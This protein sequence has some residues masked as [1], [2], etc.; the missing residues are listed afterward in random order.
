MKHMN[1]T[2]IRLAALAAA[3]LMMLLL[4]AACATLP[5][6][7]E[8][9][10][11]S[12]TA[13][14]E[15]TGTTP[16]PGTQATEETSAEAPTAPAC[17][18]TADAPGIELVW[19]HEASCFTAASSCCSCSACGYTWTQTIG[20]PNPH[21]YADG[22][23]TVCGLN[24]G[25]DTFFT[26]RAAPAG[27]PGVAYL[28]GFSADC[29][30][31][32]KS[33][34]SYV[35]PRVAFF[36]GK[37]YTIEGVESIFTGNKYVKS[38]TIP[39]G[40]TGVG[41]N[42]FKGAVNL[43]EVILPSTITYIGNS[44][45]SGCKK[46]TSLTL[47]ENVT[48]I[49]NS[50][51]ENCGGL[52]EIILPDGCSKIGERAFFNC[53]LEHITL[54][55]SL[56]TIPASMLN[57]NAHLTEITLPGE[58]V[59]I[60]EFAFS[61]TG[62]TE[63]IVPDSVTSLSLRCVT[64]TKIRRLI[65]PDSVTYVGDDLKDCPELETIRLSDALTSLAHITYLPKLRSINI[66]AALKSLG[67]GQFSGCSALEEFIISPDH[68]VLRY[69]NGMLI[70]RKDSTLI[71]ITGVTELVIPD[72]GSVL[73][74]ENDACRGRTGL[75]R[76][77]IPGC[78]ISIGQYAFE[79][80]KSLTSVEI[81]ENEGGEERMF[82]NNC[83]ENCA[84]LTAFA[85]PSRTRAMRSVLAGCTSLKEVTIPGR[86][87]PDTVYNDWTQFFLSDKALEKVIYEGTLQ[88]WK[89]LIGGT[90]LDESIPAGTRVVC[91]D[92]ET[93]VAAR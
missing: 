59:Y 43:E 45:F 54:P 11:E 82:K 7:A 68:P 57:G 10:E 9:G 55:A 23:C 92:G 60:G 39:E 49:D 72:D 51:F 65:L 15:L 37:L 33:R 79:G 66:P 74:I 21:Q 16:E 75:E 18:H 90:H 84:S 80:C 77:V 48:E 8:S 41:G 87:T 14:T 47:P 81:L 42:S 56:K 93:T 22:I 26:Y 19:H 1:T 63:L 2:F 34:E 38:V 71:A 83:F 20:E 64:G 44:A 50:A 32:E 12:Y 46:L 88:G 89:T 4:G 91:K 86:F 58:L 30:E 17:V 62:I 36:D 70:R 67:S 3:A 53:A 24:E 69:E 13:A 35:L 31:E 25:A 76:V 85:F 78:V 5:G 27:H 29:T 52:R 40:Y 61:N 6:P 73:A 28:S